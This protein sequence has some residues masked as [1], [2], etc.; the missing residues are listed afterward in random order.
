MA[1]FRLNILAEEDIIHYE[2]R[3]RQYFPIDQLFNYFATYMVDEGGK[4]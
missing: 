3:V 2:N 1:F 4:V